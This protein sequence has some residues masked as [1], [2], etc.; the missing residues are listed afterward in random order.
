MRHGHEGLAQHRHRFPVIEAVQRLTLRL[1]LTF[2]VV[3][4]LAGPAAAA[5]ASDAQQLLY[6][7]TWPHQILVFD[8]AQE[9]IV[10]RIDLDTDAIQLL[11]LAADKKRLYAN[12]VR[13]NSIVVIDL[14]SRKVL[15]KFA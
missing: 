8:T 10:D 6:L 15:S 14:A 11:V 5:D 3:G 7:A 4:L 9:K 1:A 12:T 2:L 13:D